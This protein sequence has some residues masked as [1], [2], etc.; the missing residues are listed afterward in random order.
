MARTALYCIQCGHRTHQWLGRC[1]DCSAWDSFAE[2]GAEGRSVRLVAIEDVE[3]SPSKRIS[4]GLG[5]VDRVLGGGLVGGSVV[6][7]AGEPGIGKSTLMLQIAA[8]VEAVGKR[9]LYFCGEESL[10]QVASRARRLGS[11]KKTTISDATELAQIEAL[12]GQADVAIVDSIQTIRD[13]VS[14]GEAGSVSQVRQCAAA[15]SKTARSSGAAV[16]L[17]GHICKDGSIAGPRALEHVVDAVITFE[18]D[19][20]HALRTLRGVKNRFGP[21]AELGVFEMTPQGLREV[22][23]PSGLFLD[24]RS[25]GVAGSAVGCVMEGRRPLAL[26]VQTL[27]V[28]TKATYPRR[29]AQGLDASRL[30]LALAV[31]E[32]RAEITLCACEVYASIAGGFQAAEPG[33]ELAL[34]MALAGSALDRSCPPKLAAV[35]E[36]GLGGEIR[37]VGG[38]NARI[39]ELSRL[40]FTRILA[41]SITD[42]IGSHWRAEKADIR[43]V[44]TLIEAIEWLG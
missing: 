37:P 13:P 22:A 15:L 2:T 14:P 31:L 29:V 11:V 26:E 12:L 42:S 7:L 35:G 16:V 34:C 27:T 24:S 17:V 8:G 19:R 4:T 32:R 43:P 21:T 10:E 9:V 1:P 6:L 20:G 28:P 36:V 39:E 38:M 18:G 23:D 40:G 44:R 30:G 5:E 41:P 3:P 33:I 25:H